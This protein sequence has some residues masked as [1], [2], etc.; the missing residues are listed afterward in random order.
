MPSI[1]I[2]LYPE[3][4]ADPNLDLRYALPD[5]IGEKSGNLLRDD[6]YDYGD[7]SGTMLVY[8]VTEDLEKALPFVLD[9]VENEVVLGN[10]LKDAVTV[11][12]GEY[13]HYA[14]V[15]PAGDQ[16]PFDPD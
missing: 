2:K 13:E 10:V 15:Y 12:A 4:L 1:V 6:G 11:A 5:L 3:R 9:M 16:R 7:G 8:L 14:V